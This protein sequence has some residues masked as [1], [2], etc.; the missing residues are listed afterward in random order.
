VEGLIAMEENN[1]ERP[2]EE[3]ESGFS[4]V[5]WGWALWA[6]I[7]LVFAAWGGMRALMPDDASVMAGIESIAPAAAPP[8]ADQAAP[9]P[10]PDA[11]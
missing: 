2:P 3:T 1:E 5:V 8:A 9:Q 11:N 10:Q 4:S 6:A 7:I